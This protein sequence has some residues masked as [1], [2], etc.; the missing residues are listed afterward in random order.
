MLGAVRA[1]EGQGG[2]EGG[3]EGRQ[4]R[5]SGTGP[6]PR[7]A[8]RLAGPEQ[9]GRQFPRHLLKYTVFRRFLSYGTCRAFYCQHHD[10][11][12]AEALVREY[13]G[14]I[15]RGQPLWSDRRE[16]LRQVDLHEDPGRRPRAER[17]QRRAGAERAPGQAAPGPVRV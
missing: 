10:A 7:A 6:A 11:I 16:R 8:G 3:A 9:G 13:L 4:V 5:M 15:R 17:R 2:A 12:R 1:D 14:Q